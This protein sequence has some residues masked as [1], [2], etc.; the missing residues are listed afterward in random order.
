VLILSL[1][2]D[3][4][5]HRFS[6]R[7]CLSNFDV[8]Y[9]MMKGPFSTC[10]ID[11]IIDEDVLYARQAFVARTQQCF[12]V[13]AGVDGFLDVARKSFCETTEGKNR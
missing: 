7:R 5:D 3:L 4:S 6:D 8:C 9:D 1:G 11:E 2:G 13:K 12:A 10:S